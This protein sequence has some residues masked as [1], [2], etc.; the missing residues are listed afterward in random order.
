M[1]W[2]HAVQP[3]LEVTGCAAMHLGSSRWARCPPALKLRRPGCLKPGCLKLVQS[4]DQRGV[5][6]TWLPPPGPMMVLVPLLFGVMM[7]ALP[8]GPTSC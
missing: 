1:T 6:T 4:A 5:G 3:R 7:P 8:F 2:W